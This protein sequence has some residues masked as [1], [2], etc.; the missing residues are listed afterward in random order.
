MRRP[1]IRSLAIAVAVTT[2]AT[3]TA[4][5]AANATAA[6]STTQ[7]SAPASSPTHTAIVDAARAAA[8]AH[9]SAT[10]VGKKDTLTATD[11]LVDPDGKQ[12]VRFIRTHRGLPVLGG[13]LVIHLDADSAYQDVTRAAGRQIEVRSTSP[14]LSAGQAAAKAATAAEG[15]AG[16]AELVVDARVGRTALAYQVRVTESRTDEAGGVRTVVVDAATGTVLSNIPANDSFLSPSLRK[17]LRERGEKLRPATGL[18]GSAPTAPTGTG[19]AAGAAGF[20]GAANGTGSSL[21]VGKVPLSTTQTAKN[22][23]V[24]KDSTRGKT[25]TRD[26]GGRELEKFADGK[27][28]T[29]T[30]NRWGNGRTSDR[31]TAAVDAQYGI[32]STLDFYKKTFGRKGIKNDGTGARALVHFGKNVGNAFWSSDC[33]CM[34][35]GDG[36][37]K[38]FTKPLVVLDVTGHELTH[39]V[40]DATAGLQPTRVDDDGNQFGEPGSLNESLADIFGSSVEFAADNPKNPPNYLMGEKLGL[41]QKFLRRLDKPSLDKLEGTVDYWSDK[42]YDTEV[43]AGSGVSSHAYYLLAEGSGRKKIG[44]VTY[45]SPT[46]DGSKVTGIGR[47]K[48]TAIYYRALTRYM[49]STTDFHDARAATLKAAKD[50]YGAG[51]TEYK[52]VD[53]SWAAVNVTAANAPA[54]R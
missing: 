29:S 20:P 3:I 12:H 40:V 22:R 8:Y 45:D 31:G 5:V 49:V 15:R 25:E 42:S 43:H 4:G 17:K 11:L 39:G 7:A 18:T 26:A 2:A 38:T 35:Y 30:D 36:D 27:A 51:S 41:E 6:P 34:L 33:G 9:A 19:K 46:Y 48:A 1:H 13:D 52:T 54:E 50:L 10:G 28:F 53:K 14:K 16:T 47:A 21:F 24:L 32:T 37:G 23:F 44:G